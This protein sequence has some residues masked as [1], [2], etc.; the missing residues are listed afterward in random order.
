ME[1]NL[2]KNITHSP[3]PSEKSSRLKN[4]QLKV[5]GMKDAGN[6]QEIASLGPDYL[7]FIFYEKSPRNF[8]GK[9][10]KLQGNIK[11]TGV[12]VDA[13]V[14]FIKEK[15]EEHHLKAVQLHGKESPKVCSALKS[16]GLEVIKVF[17]VKDTIDFRLL[18]EYEGK[19]DF[20]LF[21]TKG[22]EKGGN[23][24][25]FN[26]DLLKEYPSSTPFFLSGGIGLEELEKLKDLD[27]L[28]SFYGIDVNSRFETEPGMKNPDKVKQIRRGIE[29]S[30]KNS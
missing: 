10:P 29:S 7:G 1:K 25:T 26:W 8:E 6:I 16:E 21:D 18:Q 23:G 19:V 22:K 2:N 17:S 9:I 28:E 14:E 11:K 4:L 3:P 27:L 13:S 20:F 15:A 30:D 24:L 12:F 5:C